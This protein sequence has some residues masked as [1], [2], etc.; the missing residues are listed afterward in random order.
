VVGDRADPR[1]ERFARI[2][3]VAFQMNGQQ[4][5]LHDVLNIFGPASRPIQAALDYRAKPGSQGLEHLPIGYGIARS[6]GT[7]Q[8]G[9]IRRTLEHGRS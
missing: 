8:L 4:S 7:H 5:F 6:R 9:E 1:L 2:P 3:C